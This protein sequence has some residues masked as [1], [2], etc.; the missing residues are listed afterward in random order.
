[1][2]VARA[3]PAGPIVAADGRLFRPGQD[4]RGSYGNG[5]TFSEIIE[6]STERYREVPRAQIRVAG[7]KG[8][9]T[10]FLDGD[11]TVVDSYVERLTPLAG[12]TRLKNRVTLS[13]G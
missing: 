12:I 4:N 9:H 5:V 10:L 13:R 6:L 3:R 1:M 8:P 2:D 7:R 11:S